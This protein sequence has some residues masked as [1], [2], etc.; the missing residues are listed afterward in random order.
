MTNIS[1]TPSTPIATTPQASVL[2]PS[3]IRA[4]STQI[5]GDT[6]LSVSTEIGIGFT[7][8]NIL[9]MSMPRRLVNCFSLVAWAM[10]LCSS[11]LAQNIQYTQNVADLSMRSNINV[12]PSTLGMTLQIPLRQYPGR[13]GASL[14]ATLHYSS[15]VLRINHEDTSLQGTLLR[16]REQAKYAEHSAAGWT[17][18][19]DPPSI[20]N[21]GGSQSFDQFGTPICLDVKCQQPKTRWYI[22]RLHVHMP[23][24]SSHELRK[25]DIPRE[26]SPDQT[27]NYYSVDGS[28]LRYNYDNSTLYLP[29]GSR[30]I[31]GPTTTQYIDRNG[32]TLTFTISTRKWTDSL[33]RL[34]GLPLPQQPTSGD[35]TY[36]LPGV[37][38]TSVS[39][40]FRWKTLSQ[41]RSNPSEP[42]RYAGDR[43]FDNP[44][45]TLS[46]SLFTSETLDFICTA[47]LFNPVVLSEIELPN[48]RK[49][50]FT[51]N[52]WGEIDKVIYPTGGYERFA[53][54]TI[55]PLSRITGVY[56]EGNRGVTDRWVSVSGSGPDRGDR[57]RE[58]REPAGE[59][60]LR[61]V[62]GYPGLRPAL[63]PVRHP[64]R[65]PAHP[66]LHHRAGGPHRGQDLRRVQA[67]QGDL[68]RD[69]AAGRALRGRRGE[70][71][72]QHDRE[73][74]VQ[75]A[76]AVHGEPR[77]A[78]ADP[79]GPDP[80]VGRAD[81]R[82]GRSA[83]SGP[84]A[85]RHS[86]G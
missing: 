12:D 2:F 70:R 82:R 11:A 60:G 86:L 85:F 49:Y 21:T 62:H 22:S 71:R 41:V 76:V 32:N 69:R 37:D 24:G 72:R 36:T 26:N 28:Q 1:I 59:R 31:F 35:V 4:K 10:I 8:H 6:S 58:H 77:L 27:G 43:T 23:D 44:A 75:R 7:L 19:L 78:A 46:P 40:I 65:G 47:G 14:S 13:G 68:P 63:R 79:A 38:G 39:Y 84:G 18:S 5:L 83:R 9:A 45:Q 42:L 74:G 73:A 56:N 17:S 61:L 25:D 51:Y 33:G 67:D 57:E 53:F 55:E 3:L 34:I 81:G 80:A 52:I 48:E 29:D 66:Q 54:T 30:Y 50:T 20:E 16:T 64:D 15:K